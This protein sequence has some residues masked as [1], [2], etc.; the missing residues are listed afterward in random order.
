MMKTYFDSS[1]F[2][3]RYIEESGSDLLDSV[4]QETDYLGLSVITAAEIFSALNRR[5]RERS[6]KLEEYI[7]AKSHLIADIRDAEIIDLTNEVISRT[8]SI[9][10]KSHL[11]TLDAIHV[12]SAYRWNADLFVSSDIRQLK[13]AEEAGLKIY[14]I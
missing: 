3:K 10:E 1:S 14:Q 4:F 12:A 13:A 11:R 9:L 7:L 2:A 6:I 5:K 8:I